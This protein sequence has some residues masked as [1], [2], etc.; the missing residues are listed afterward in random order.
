M[1]QRPDR[2]GKHRMRSA[3]GRAH[4]RSVEALPA[5]LV[6]AWKLCRKPW[7]TR[8]PGYIASS[9][10]ASGAASSLPH[11]RGGHGHMR[12]RLAA[13]PSHPAAGL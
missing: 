7:C 10:G 13:H 1:P 12:S 6:T 3:A 4:L 2:E 8:A 11:R 5:A 9:T